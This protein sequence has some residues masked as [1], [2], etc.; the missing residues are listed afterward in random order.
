M[1]ALARRLRVLL[2]SARGDVGGGRW[3]REQKKRITWAT[4]SAK[5][6]PGPRSHMTEHPFSGTSACTEPENVDPIS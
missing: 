1:C 3:S 2:L 4:I 5:T 6:R